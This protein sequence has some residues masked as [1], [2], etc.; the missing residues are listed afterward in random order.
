MAT[1]LGV[2]LAAAWPVGLLCCATWL[3]A[4]KLGRIS[5]LAALTAAALSPLFAFLLHCPG[6][7]T[8][9]LAGRPRRYWFFVAP[10]REHRPR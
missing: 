4:A 7:P 3:V 10:S 6:M 2:L 9:S 1:F 8:V 5:S